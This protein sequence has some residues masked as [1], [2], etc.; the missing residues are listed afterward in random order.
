MSAEKRLSGLEE[1]KRLLVL[2]A[3]LQRALLRA[4]AARAHMWLECLGLTR[5]RLR[6]SPWLLAAG[7]AAGLLAARQGRGALK[8]L[9]TALAACHM[10]GLIAC[11]G[12]PHLAAEN[13]VD[14]HRVGQH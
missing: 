13:P 8:W 2:E 6:A 7:L 11:P 9:S 1:R 14:T 5:R 3:D 12:E 10:S 4:Q